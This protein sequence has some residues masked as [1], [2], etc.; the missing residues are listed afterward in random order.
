MENRAGG[1]MRA[2][3]NGR[4]VYVPWRGRGRGRGRTDGHQFRSRPAMVA[5]AKKAAYSP[6]SQAIGCAVLGSLAGWLVGALCL[7]LKNIH[8]SSNARAGGARWNVGSVQ[9]RRSGVGTRVTNAHA[10]LKKAGHGGC[11][12]VACGMCATVPVIKWCH[13]AHL[14]LVGFIALFFVQHVFGLSFS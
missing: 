6:A 11:V 12:V 10:E 1:R 2:R 14:R 3:A 5:A 9:C 13:W 8:C 7:Y 4:M